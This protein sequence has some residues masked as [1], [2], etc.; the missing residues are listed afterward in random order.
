[1]PL[2]IPGTSDAYTMAT[3]TEAFSRMPYVPSQINSLPIH[4][5]GVQTTTVLVEHR[6]ETFDLIDER[7]YN[8]GHSQVDLGKADTDAMESLTIPHYP[9]GFTI[10]ATEVRA[11]RQ[12]G[13]ETEFE[14]TEDRQA[15]FFQTWQRSVN[16]NWEY[17]GIGGFLFGVILDRN[18]NVRYDLR[19][20]LKRQPLR[21]QFNFGSGDNFF[22]F[23]NGAKWLAQQALG[24]YPITGWTLLGDKPMNDKVIYDPSVQKTYM[25]FESLAFLRADNTARPFTICDDVKVEVYRNALIPRTNKLAF[26]TKA[27]VLIPQAEN[28][29]QRRFAPAQTLTS[30]NEPGAPVYL[31]PFVDPHNEFVEIKGQTNF[32]SWNQ[33]YEG[34]IIIEHG[35]TTDLEALGYYGQD[36]DSVYDN[37]EDLT[38]E[39]LG[40]TDDDNGNPRGLEEALIA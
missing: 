7:A 30:I 1:M 23:I 15:R 6:N 18:G 9:H 28:L 35:P 16:F 20:K 14:M 12:F 10:R 40:I 5:E 31:S 36:T 13:S 4:S 22:K 26:P 17:A 25:G 38:A 37:V 19:K 34:V 24:A 3:L 32:I 21:L 11:R 2:L 27:L 8:S 33:R 29:F 39:Q